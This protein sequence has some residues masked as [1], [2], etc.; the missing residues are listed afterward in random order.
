L[1]KS[2]QPLKDLSVLPNLFEI[3]G[4]EKMKKK[5]QD[6]SKISEKQGVIGDRGA[7]S[8]KLNSSSGVANVIQ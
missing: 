5:P 8:A 1:K 4:S 7:G 3:R 2:N 6:R